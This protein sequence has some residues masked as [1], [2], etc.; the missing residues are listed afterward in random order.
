MLET[1]WLS[2][3]V[4]MDSMNDNVSHILPVI[5]LKFMVNVGTVNIYAIHEAYRY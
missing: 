4:S 1:S 2:F 3:T 5:W